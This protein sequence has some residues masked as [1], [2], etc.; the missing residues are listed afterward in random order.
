MLPFGSFLAFNLFDQL[1]N[2]FTK[3][4]SNIF[5]K[6]KHTN[7]NLTRFYI[8]IIFNSRQIIFAVS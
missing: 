4:L 3:I 8:V 7:K 6:S 2:L 5:K 1:N